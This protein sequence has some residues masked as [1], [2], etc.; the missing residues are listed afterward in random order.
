MLSYPN[1]LLNDVE[2]AW[3]TKDA[4]SIDPRVS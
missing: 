1:V 4:F 3:Q 2:K